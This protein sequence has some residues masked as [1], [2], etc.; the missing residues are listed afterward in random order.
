MGE[1]LLGLVDDFVEHWPIYI[2]IPIV[3][4]LI[5]WA[6]KLVAIR[7]MFEPL[8]FRGIRWRGKPLFG[9]QGIVPRRAA[10]MAGIAVDTMTEQLISPRDIVE[11]LDPDRIGKEIEAPLREAVGEIVVDVAER[12]QPGLWEALPVRARK[13]VIRRVQNEAPKMV[14][15]VTEQIKADVDSVFDLKDMVVTNLV[16][17][18]ELLNRIFL[19]AGE[20]EFRFISRSGVLFGFAIGILQMIVWLVLRIPIVMP[21]FGLFIGWFTDWIALKMIFRPVKPKKYF[22]VTWQ[23]LFVKRRDEVTDAYAALIADE[24]ITP[25]NVIDAVLR[26]PMSDRVLSM[27][28]QQVDQELAR[29]T[30]VAKPLVLLAMGGSQYRELKDAIAG[31]V[32]SRLPE[33][34]RYVETYAADAMDIR[35]TLI[36]K[37][38]EL[39]DEEF[40]GLLRPAFQQD[41]WILIMT[42]ALLGGLCGE[43]QVQLVLFLTS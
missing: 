13:L 38:R 11:R 26:G 32:M 43:L 2:S 24:I 4:A 20:K 37:M 3:A 10:R 18:K 16:K 42:G 15:A 29:H 7:M 30:G 28:Q 5:G 23:G 35:G 8:E 12:Y 17:D 14:A 40:E 34:L 1:Y 19:E 36:T 41:E 9:W 39:D 25:P 33:T 27:I 21:I 31:S 6:T 22:G